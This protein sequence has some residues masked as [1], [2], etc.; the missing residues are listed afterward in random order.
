MLW[1]LYVNLFFDKSFSKHHTFLC[2]DHYRTVWSSLTS[3]EDGLCSTSAKFFYFEISALAKDSP[4]SNQFG[5]WLDLVAML[6]KV[7]LDSVRA[8]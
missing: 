3:L 2:L 7:S 8:L 1:Y 5:V 4:S 6:G